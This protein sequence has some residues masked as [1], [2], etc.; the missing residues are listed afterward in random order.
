[1]LERLLYVRTEAKS[2]AME[3]TWNSRQNGEF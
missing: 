1:M 3:N 2:A